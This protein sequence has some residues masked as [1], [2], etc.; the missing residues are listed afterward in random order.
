MHKIDPG[1]R[2]KN[3]GTYNTRGNE[4][5]QLREVKKRKGRQTNSPDTYLET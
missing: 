5:P 4:T 2:E 3:Y 1:E